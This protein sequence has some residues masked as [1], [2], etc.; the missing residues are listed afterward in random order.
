M[1][2]D[3]GC[4][5]RTHVSPTARRRGNDPGNSAP[6]D[7]RHLRHGAGPAVPEQGVDGFPA[8]AA[9]GNR[10]VAQVTPCVLTSTVGP[11]ANTG[12]TD[13]RRPT[14][15]YWTLLPPVLDSQGCAT[16][17]GMKSASEVNRLARERKLPSVKFGKRVLFLTDEVIATLRR[18][19]KPAVEDKDLGRVRRIEKVAEGQE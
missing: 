1:S 4:R 6:A 16:L 3:R 5:H 19:Q 8:A 10:Q 18:R 17:L 13:G 9:A 14:A 11:E 7:T 15:T 12:A 2:G